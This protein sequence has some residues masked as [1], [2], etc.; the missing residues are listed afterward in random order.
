MN[1]CSIGRSFSHNEVKRVDFVS[2]RTILEFDAVFI[3]SAGISE[4]LHNLQAVGFRINEFE[5]FLSLGRTIVV[6]IGSLNLAEFLPMDGYFALQ[7]ISGENFDLKGSD[8]LKSF[9]ESVE[10]DMQYLA[11]FEIN[12]C[13][14]KP[15]LFV[16]FTNRAVGTWVKFEKGN[17]LLLP[18]FYNSQGNPVRYMEACQRFVSAFR[19]LNEFLVPKKTS[20]SL[21]PWSVHYGWER[22]QKLRTELLALN[23][24]SAQLEKE[25]CKTT[26]ELEIED[27]LKA[28]FTAKSE[29]LVDSVTSVLKELGAKLAPCDPGRD[30]IIFEF[31]GKH[32]VVEVKGKKS[33]AAEADAAQLEKWVAGFKEQKGTDAKGVLLI[34]AYC[35]TP[36]ADRTEAP[37]PNQML[38]YST[39]RQHCLITTTQLLGILIEA[40]SHPEKRGELL[41][42]LFSTDGVYQKCSDWNKFLTVTVPTV[43]KA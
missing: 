32:A 2:T 17:L 34:N 40:R 29:T 41:N 20:V 13:P 10:Q 38:K 35:E 33:S 4:E 9:W 6:F 25:I 43:V 19:K 31:E 24:K 3:D 42:S 14:G 36:L 26:S 21:P 15:F 8:F 16:P 1:I 30:D 22:E 27:N 12:N 11:H 39:Q 18:W 5:E 23:K 28:L 7:A 37:F